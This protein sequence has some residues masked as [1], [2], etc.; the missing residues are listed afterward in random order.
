MSW[1]LQIA[2]PEI[3]TAF[4]KE[5]IALSLDGLWVRRLP[6]NLSCVCVLLVLLVGCQHMYNMFDIYMTGILCRLQGSC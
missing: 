6:T 5:T 1:V 2:R 4:T 3:T